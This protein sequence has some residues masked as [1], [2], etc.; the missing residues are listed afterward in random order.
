MMIDDNGGSDRQR[1]LKKSP[2][3][4]GADFEK[5]QQRAHNDKE[6]IAIVKDRDSNELHYI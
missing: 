3:K 6:I 2:H 4:A 1:I 5:D